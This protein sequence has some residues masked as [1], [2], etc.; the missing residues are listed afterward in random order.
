[1]L[2]FVVLV[3]ALERPARADDALAPL[4][5]GA[6]AVGGE[7]GRRIDVTIDNNLLKLDVDG[8]FL[9]PFRRKSAVAKSAHAS[10]YVGL[11][12]LIDATV[13]FA[14]YRKD[15]RLA[16]LRNHLIGELLRTQLPDGYLGIF[17]EEDRVF[18]LWD[19]HE[20]VYVIH[21]L[22]ADYRDSGNKAS[23]DAARRLADYVM[24]RRK[25]SD[26]PRAVGKLDTERALVALSRATGDK[27]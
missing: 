24:A 4:E 26:P 20:M 2:V 18:A 12:K 16:E 14:A 6:V 17:R 11:G 23:L 19:L 3:T 25:G 22:V 5:A 15:R 27:K 10:R 1:M 13:S 21:G 8:D 9:E 7:I